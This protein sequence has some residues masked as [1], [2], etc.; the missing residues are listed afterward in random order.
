MQAIEVGKCGEAT[1]EQGAGC[2]PVSGRAG[3][4][5]RGHRHVIGQGGWRIERRDGKAG[6][7]GGMTRYEGMRRC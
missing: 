2:G 7:H 6:W 4:R 1:K 3:Y 5:A